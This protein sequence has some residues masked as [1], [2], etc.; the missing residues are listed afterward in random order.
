MWEEHVVRQ[1]LAG[2][3][4]GGDRG[5]A[6]LVRILGAEVRVLHDELPRMSERLVPD[7]EG[8][9]QRGA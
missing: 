9:A 5:G 6:L 1:V 8:G 3:A 2:Q 7:V 4:C